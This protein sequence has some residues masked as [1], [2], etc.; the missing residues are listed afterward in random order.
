MFDDEELN[1][2]AILNMSDEEKEEWLFK[3]FDDAYLEIMSMLALWEK[4]GIPLVTTSELPSLIKALSLACY[5]YQQRRGD[6]L[7]GKLH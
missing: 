5:V 7:Q 2:V 3:N 1:A 4:T 6:D